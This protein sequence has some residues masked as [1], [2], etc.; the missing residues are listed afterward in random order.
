VTPELALKLIVRPATD[1]LLAMSSAPAHAM[2]LAIG[3]QESGWD[4][5]RQMGNG[6][7]RGWWQF[8]AGGGVAGVL[9][10]RASKA[11]A[12]EVCDRLH[13]QATVPIVHDALEHCDA[14]AACFARLLLWTDPRPLPAPELASEQA[15]WDY[16][17]R[18][19]RP[20]KPHRQ[21]W[22]GHW[23]RACQVVELG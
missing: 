23:R 9:T 12:A 22:G 20:G 6:P 8:E 10:H 14:L 18:N 1:Y 13:V 16:Y 19:W 2:M 3:G 15:A 11:L 4:H 21:T 7:A 5:R 17:M